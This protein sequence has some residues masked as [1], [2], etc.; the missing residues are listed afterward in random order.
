LRPGTY[1]EPF[2][3]RALGIAC[4]DSQ[5]L[6]RAVVRFEENGLEWHARETQK[7]RS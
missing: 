1:A 4:D 6:E 5:L 7:L 2:A 3:L